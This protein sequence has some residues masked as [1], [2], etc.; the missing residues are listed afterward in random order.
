M[1]VANASPQPLTWRDRT[2]IVFLASKLRRWKEALITVQP[3]TVFRWH[4]DPFR[5]YSR[6]KS[7]SRTQSGRPPLTEDVVA[8]IERMAAVRA[9]RENATWGAERIRGELS[10]IGVEVS[11]SLV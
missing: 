1:R 10:K 2:L 11:K 3:D 8:L 5:H 6:R 9:A 7:K 4:R